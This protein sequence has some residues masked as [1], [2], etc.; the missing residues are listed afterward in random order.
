[1]RSP[2][3]MRRTLPTRRRCWPATSPPWND[4][5]KKWIAGERERHSLTPRPMREPRECGDRSSSAPPIALAVRPIVAMALALAGSGLAG[6]AL[7]AA[8]VSA[9]RPSPRHRRRSPDRSTTSRTSSTRRH[10]RELERR[11]LALQTGLGRCRRGRHGAIDRAVLG[12]QRVRRAD[13]RERRDAGSVRKARTTAPS[14]C[15]R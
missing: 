3:P 8:P 10:E 1:M 7:Q 14:S 4:S 11:I 13:V 2:L 6:S 9:R 5:G 12:H 15:W